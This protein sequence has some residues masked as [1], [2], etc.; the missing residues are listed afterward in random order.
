MVSPEL[1]REYA[2]RGDR[3]DRPRRREWRLLL[4]ELSGRR[5]RS[6]RSSSS[7]A[8]A[9]RVRRPEM[10]PEPVA[11][12]GMA[13]VFPGAGDLA[14]FWRNLVGGVD[15]ITDVPPD[16][17]ATPCSS[18]PRPDRRPTASTAGAAASSTTLAASTRPPSASCRSPSAGTEPDQLL[19]LSHRGRGP[20]RRRRRRTA[21]PTRSRVGVDPRPRRLPHPGH[22]PARPAG[23][24]R[25]PA[26]R[27]ACASWCPT[28]ATTSSPRCATQ[29]HDALGPTSPRPSIGLVPNLA[30]SRIA[31]RLDLQGPGLHASTRPAPR[32]W[33]PSTRPSTSWR[34][35]A[36]TWCS[37][38]ASTTATTSRSGACSPSSGRSAPASAI[39]PFDRRRRRHPDRRGHRH[40]RAQAARRRRARRRSDL[41][42]RSA[43]RAWRATAAPP[44][45]MSPASRAARCWRS[46]GPG[47]RPGSTPADASG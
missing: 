5:C 6:R 33:S 31:N 32:R 46:S 39:R 2:R 4:A 24:H 42:R 26:G 19:A 15:A 12:V 14:T 37:P 44:S 23:A 9:R 25:A 35:A 36:A 17:G 7:C 47:G 8:R 3:P 34:R 18:H 16:R 41:R 20:R 11:V 27:A 28:S 43:G 21:C 1:A 40:R 38:A 13:A 30:A 10:G 45:L 29:F 22:R